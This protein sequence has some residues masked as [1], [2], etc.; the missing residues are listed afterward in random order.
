MGPKQAKQRKPQLE[1]EY[2]SQKAQFYSEGPTINS[3][4]KLFDQVD[5]LDLSRKPDRNQLLYIVH[6]CYYLRQYE[7][8]LTY[9]DLGLNYFSDVSVNSKVNKELQELLEIKLKCELKLS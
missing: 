5:T 9:I 3:E 6:R 7:K 8:C 4:E 1:E 2:L